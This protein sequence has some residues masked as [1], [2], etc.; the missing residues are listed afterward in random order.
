MDFGAK[1]LDK[2]Q[3]LPTPLNVFHLFIDNWMLFQRSSFDH[4]DDFG[5]PYISQIFL[6]EMSTGRYIHRSQGQTVDR[7]TSLDL[8]ALA[9]K[10][11]Q[12][13]LGTQPCHGLP[14]QN[15]ALVSNT[16]NILE[17]PFR[18]YA[19]EQC[20]FYFN[21][22]EMKSESI[23]DETKP[24]SRCPA[25]QEAWQEARAIPVDSGFG[26]DI[27]KMDQDDPV[28]H[29]VNFDCDI[30]EDADI[31]SHHTNLR[32]KV[33]EVNNQVPEDTIAEEPSEL[34][35]AYKCKCCSKIF[36]T[37][38]AL[39][40]HARKRKQEERA[41]RKVGCR[42]CDDSDIVTFTQLA[43]HVAKH[44]SNQ[45]ANY[46]NFFPHEE[47]L[48]L[49]KEPMKCTVCDMINNGSAL[50][51]RHR[52]IYHDLGDYSCAECQEPCLTY[53][54]LVVH[55]YQKHGKATDH[56]PP[57]PSSLKVIVHEDGKIEYKKSKITCQVCLK[58]YSGSL[59][60]VAHMRKKH[61]WGIF[62]CRPC[63]GSCHF[64][65]DISAHVLN[66]H[67]D[68][69]EIECPNC[70]RIFCLEKDPGVF[71]AHFQ[72]CAP[73]PI[74]RGPFQ[75]QFCGKEYACKISLNAHIKMHQGIIKFKC[76][77]CDFGSNHRNVWVT[78]EKMHLR[79]LGLCP[80]SEEHRQT[81]QCDICG[82]QLANRLQ[83]NQHIRAMH[84][85]YKRTFQC[86]ICGEFLKYSAA[87]YKHKKERHGY[88]PKSAKLTK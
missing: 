40:C 37:Q 23:D 48:S 34:R 29:L 88:V 60:F 63:G 87:L 19:S 18:R 3:A 77:Y 39:T 26:D 28:E 35:K 81:Q 15:K 80:E 14:F 46:T 42:E 65:K 38:S 6:I 32:P 9:S 85:G 55:N 36:Q 58:T 16:L 13:F 50:S 62:S 56:I 7:G 22:S 66:F 74:E 10:L 2:L 5:D 69:P 11:T 76:Q 44:H 49:M 75:C 31:W 64:A 24:L 57:S 30:N 72:K 67:K 47:D 53:Y 20:Q 27:L 68:R 70:Q 25:C 78:H 61:S 79:K 41:K 17:Y 52:E 71:T 43:V 83:V 1:I 84:K 45:L 86:K 59:G 4:F 73:L 82:K 33:N 12:V 8:E 51:H 21:V 54:D